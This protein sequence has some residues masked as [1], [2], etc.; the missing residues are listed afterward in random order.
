M[1]A[2][3]PEEYTTSIFR[4]EEFANILASSLLGLGLLFVPEDEHST[5]LR[6][7]Y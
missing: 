7:V 6:N 2:D 4:A 5:F 1:F 3:I